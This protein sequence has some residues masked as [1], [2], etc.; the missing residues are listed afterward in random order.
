MGLESRKEMK[1]K[2]KKVSKVYLEE[3]L[4][5]IKCKGI[6]VGDQE[7][8]EMLQCISSRIPIPIESFAFVKNMSPRLDWIVIAWTRKVQAWEKS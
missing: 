6:W 7:H 8:D 4:I 5:D 3:K 2:E 1:K